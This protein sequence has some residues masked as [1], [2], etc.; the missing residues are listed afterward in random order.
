MFT[1]TQWDHEVD[2]VCIGAESGVLAAGI[3]AENAG[4]D[5]YL[6]I[7]ETN[8]GAGDLAG[9]RQPGIVEQPRAQRDLGFV[10]RIGG[11]MLHRRQRSELG[12]HR[13]FLKHGP[14]PGFRRPGIG[15][16]KL[17]R[18]L[19]RLNPGDGRP[20]PGVQHAHDQGEHADVAPRDQ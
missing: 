10:R 12:E 17:D 4:F 6:G 7:S 11:G 15:R 1:E 5:A 16:A 14:G 18:R 20:G 8:P 3:V 2:V 13:P 9:L 19:R